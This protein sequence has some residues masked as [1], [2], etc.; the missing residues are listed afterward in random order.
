MKELRRI[1]LAIDTALEYF[2]LTALVTM[3][4]IVIVQVLTRKLFSFVFFWSE[5][6][7]LLLLAWFAYLGIA[8]GFRE[9]LHL[10]IDL[11][12]KILPEKANRILDKIIQIGVFCFGIYLIFS[13][14]TFTILTWES[15]LAATHL[16]NGILYA[17]IPITGFM[18][19]VYTALQFCGVDT[20]RHEE[21]LKEGGH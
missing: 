1:A 2:C 18:V 16:P 5:E 14:V 15:T 11:I 6:M 10:E 20:K 21:L 13:G 17:V 9:K 7:T 4:I 3:T 12:A 8:F 19:C